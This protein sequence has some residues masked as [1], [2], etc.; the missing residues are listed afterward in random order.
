MTPEMS[1][2]AENQ[3]GAADL[4]DQRL[5][6]RAVQI[7]ACMAAQAG[8]PLS[9]QMGSRT[10]LVAAYRL[11]SNPKVSGG[12]LLAPHRRQTRQLAAHEA[13][14]L[15]IQDR[16][17]LDY[18]SH[19]R[20]TVGLGEISTARERRGV[21]LQSVLAVSGH[22]HRVL[23]LAHFERLI[24]DPNRTPKRGRKRSSSAEGQA[25][26]KAVQAIGPVPPGAVWVYVSDRESD[27]YEYLTT[28]LAH[29]ADFV[30]RAFHERVV[31][32]RE[33][34]E[35]QANEVTHLLTLVRQLP[36][37]PEAAASY[38][39]EVTTTTPS[40]AR[41]KRL[42]QVSLTWCEVQLRPPW[43]A[44]RVSPIHVRVV[45]VW[46][47]QPPSGVEPLEWI[48]LTSRPIR[49]SAEARQC[50]T[51]YTLRP[52]IEDFHMCLKTGCQVE[53]SQ[54]NHVDDLERLLGFVLPIAVRLLQLRQEVRTLPDGA[55]EGA[56]DPLYVQLL[57]AR[58]RLP[59]TTLT[60]Q[61]FWYRVAQ[62]GGYQGRASDGPPG[63]RTL[64]RGWTLLTQLAEGARLIQSSS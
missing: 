44:Q 51:W 30:V 37:N 35:A 62:L 20:R 50:V 24:R 23:G 55:A 4:G 17:S 42:A 33:P 22:S 32:K 11:L 3:W 29:G 7:G 41:Q 45:R 28:C 16:T 14:T 5:T 59:P 53:R 43:Y 49:S 10:A 56:L 34:P 52:L 21:L 63:W 12:Q 6:R 15:L 18:S 2:W 61:D 40:R 47:P 19:R 26:E 58:L 9:Q 39:V 1:N 64:W 31:Q 57:R 27:I 48:L 60:L 36:A 25:W 13:V 46:E 38:T 54:L 8:A